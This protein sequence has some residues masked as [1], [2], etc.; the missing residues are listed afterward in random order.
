[1]TY[2]RTAGDL[3]L[4]TTRPEA[5]QAAATWASP[6]SDRAY[7]TRTGPGVPAERRPSVG[8]GQV[9]QRV[10]QKRLP[11]TD[12][13]EDDDVAGLLDE[14]QAASAPSGEGCCT[15]R[16]RPSS[17]ATRGYVPASDAGPAT[18]YALAVRR[19][20]HPHM[21]GSGCWRP[22]PCRATCA[23]T[24]SVNSACGL[25]SQAPGRLKIAVRRLAVRHPF[26]R[27][28]ACALPRLVAAQNLAH[29]CH[30]Q[31]P[32][33]HGLL[34]GQAACA[35]CPE[36]WLRQDHPPRELPHD[37]DDDLAPCGWRKCPSSGPMGLETDIPAQAFDLFRRRL[38]LA[39][40]PV[41]DIWESSS[42]NGFADTVKQLH[43]SL[44]RTRR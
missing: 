32:K 30:R 34:L 9:A 42:T 33:I 41:D 28:L 4:P 15:R 38:F 2:C 14:T 36:P 16:P 35:T 39:C 1:M 26:T 13:L 7:H 10:G 37:S 23:T 27:H 5:P 11:A 40:C 31:F 20:L 12:G 24:S 44:K 6:A 3:R 17:P 8:Y 43:F 18:P 21:E 19:Q 22:W 25:T 29:V